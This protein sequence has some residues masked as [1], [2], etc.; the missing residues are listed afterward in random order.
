LPAL[1][2]PA[3]KTSPSFWKRERAISFSSVSFSRNDQLPPTVATVAGGSS[4]SA[5]EAA[6]AVDVFV[7]LSVDSDETA[8]SAAALEDLAL[9]PPPVRVLGIVQSCD[10]LFFSSS[11][12][13]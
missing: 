7:A 3:P 1:I 9:L 11:L 8:A 13:F 2:F 10:V 5:V 6:V 4:V 12:C